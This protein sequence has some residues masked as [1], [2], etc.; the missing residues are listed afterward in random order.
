[1][2]KKHQSMKD[3]T[4]VSELIVERARLHDSG[5]YVCRSSRSNV[6]NM[7]VTVLRGKLFFAFVYFVLP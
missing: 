2:I 7:K 6:V 5:E 3:K 4:F 1:M